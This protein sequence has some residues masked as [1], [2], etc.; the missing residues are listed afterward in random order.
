MARI[1]QWYKLIIFSVLTCSVILFVT[2]GGRTA[3]KFMARLDQFR[4]HLKIMRNGG[5]DPD[6]RRKY[7]VCL[8]ERY[9]IQLG[10]HGSCIIGSWDYE[11]AEGYN[12]VSTTIIAK[13]YGPNV[14]KRCSK[15]AIEQYFTGKDMSEEVKKLWIIGFEADEDKK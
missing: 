10:E 9:N 13:R 4:G 3:G 11:Y 14:L 1:R 7:S 5:E 6:I 15:V 2:A 8:L 12:S